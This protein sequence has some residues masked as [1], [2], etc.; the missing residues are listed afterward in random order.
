MLNKGTTW[1]HFY[2]VYGMTRSLTGDWGPP[3]LV[4][5]TIPLGYQ[6]GNTVLLMWHM[7][8]VYCLFNKFQNYNSIGY[9]VMLDGMMTVLRLAEIFTYSYVMFTVNTWL[10]RQ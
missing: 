4:A 6:G 5:S 7:Y 2:K 8:L 10:T 3:A 9:K 1:Y